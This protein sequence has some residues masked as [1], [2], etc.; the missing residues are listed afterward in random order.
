MN[1]KITTILELMF[2]V[3]I[4]VAQP[5]KEE[6]QSCVTVKCHAAMEKEG[7]VYYPVAVTDCSAC[8]Q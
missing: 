6:K 7:F 1:L 2:C 3:I 8:H 4:S 5:K